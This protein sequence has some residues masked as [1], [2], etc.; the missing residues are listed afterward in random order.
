MT[1]YLKESNFEQDKFYKVNKTIFIDDRIMDDKRGSHNSVILYMG[2]A[3]KISLSK[4]KYEKEYDASFMDLKGQFFCTFPVKTAREE[5]RIKRTKYNEHKA[6]LKEIGLIHYAEQEIKKEG[7]ASRIYITPWDVWVKENGLYSDGEWIVQ[8]S[9]KDFYNP[10]DIV[11]V[12]PIIEKSVEAEI[13]QEQQESTKEDELQEYE[14]IMKEAKALGLKFHHAKRI[15]E[16]N[17][18][19]NKHLGVGKRFIDSTVENLSVLRLCYE[20]MRKTFY[21]E[22]DSFDF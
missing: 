2:I 16:L 11:T 6:F 5:L 12:Q 3:D 14:N 8:P 19:V 15:D 22:T 13:K 1:S 4:S 7:D 10:E 17:L 18:I 20:E 21:R 9:S